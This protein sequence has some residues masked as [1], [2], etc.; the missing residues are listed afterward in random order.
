MR[1]DTE[2]ES[3]NFSRSLEGAGG[4]SLT[5]VEAP[6]G[7]GP[8][9]H[10]HPYDEVFV[11]HEGEGTFTAGDEEQVVAGEAV[12]VVPA[13]TPHR[14]VNTGERPLRVTTIHAS[15]RFETEWLV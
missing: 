11:V 14:F 10:R 12:I 8:S 7:S 5:L 6:P 9:L 2:L 1:V 13:G 3:G 4:L 15:P